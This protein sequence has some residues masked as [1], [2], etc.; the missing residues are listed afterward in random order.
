MTSCFFVQGSS[1]TGRVGGAARFLTIVGLGKKDDATADA[2]WGP[3][4]YQVGIVAVV[5]LS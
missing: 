3:S 2:E 1:H 4:V 5:Q